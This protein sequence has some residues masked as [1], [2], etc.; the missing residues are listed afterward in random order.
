[1]YNSEHG[2]CV[3]ENL[4]YC[5]VRF[6]DADDTVAT[7]FYI[8]SEVPNEMVLTVCYKLHECCIPQLQNVIAL[9]YDLF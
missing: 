7:A 6:C 3:I 9:K 1:M 5:A 2:Y 8:K 4:I